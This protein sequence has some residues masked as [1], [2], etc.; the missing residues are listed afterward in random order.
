MRKFFFSSLCL[1]LLPLVVAAQQPLPNQSQ[2]QQ[3]AQPQLPAASSAVATRKP[4]VLATMLEAITLCNEGAQDPKLELLVHALEFC[5]VHGLDGA[6]TVANLLDQLEPGGPKGD[7]QVGYTATLQL[8][9]L[10]KPTSDGRG[11]KIDE[12]AVDEV[13]R[14]I[15]KV[16]RPVV[17]Y[18]MGG[19]FDSTGPITGE[20]AK[21]ESNF[22]HF[23][24]GS[25]PDLGYF[26]Y[27]IAPYTLLSDPEIPVNRLRFD[28]L[29]YFA[30]RIAAL[31]ETARNRIIA[32]T[33]MGEVHQLFPDFE[34][35]VG[36][37]E[38][39][40]VTDYSAPSI[41]QFRDWLKSEYHSIA[42]F[43]EKTGFSYASF[44]EVPA[45]SKDIRR[46]RLESFAEHY[47]AFADGTL[48]FS[49]WLWDPK[50]Q[51]A[52][53]ELYIDA[54]RI[55]EVPRGQ[56]RLDVYRALEEVDD[57]NIGFRIDYD[58]S[59]LAPGR[60]VA[61][62]VAESVDGKRHPLA[63]SEFT[64][65]A[66]DQAAPPPGALRELASKADGAIGGVRSLL[67]RVRRRG[68]DLLDGELTGVRS[69]LD[70]PK[71]QQDIYFNPLARDWNA[72]RA[73][74]VER[75]LATVYQVALDAGLPADKLYSHQIVPDVNSTWNPQL[76]AVGKTIGRTLPWK[77]G[78]NMYGGATDSN[79]MRS[80]MKER[81]I[82][83][84][85]VPEFNPQQWKRDGVAL[86]ALKS[87]YDAGARFVS[88]YY[89]SLVPDRFKTKTIANGLNN[90]EL[91]PTNTRD[92]SNRFYD[93]IVEFA[94]R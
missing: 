25:V 4:L 20:L 60:H 23:A 11:W 54:Q 12:V 66:R 70:L 3:L 39:I 45:P 72:F 30:K 83:D 27:R 55:G 81:G 35:G 7:V 75:F 61:Q 62:I 40:R 14:V 82:T 93:A 65:V 33:L 64:L 41:A 91:G 57:P 86:Q 9:G 76:F 69:W 73:W 74:Q 68:S 89:F 22:M 26:G 63:R 8:L 31:P 38:D 67:E 16:D 36:R 24:D 13:L 53:L 46:E 10:Y 79:W 34:N 21:D 17:V 85:G 6:T 52:R 28:A 37:Y 48:P 77:T 19:H 94:K 80:Y 44:A 92:G 18:F 90:M 29:R 78:L 50:K 58:F 42:A 2:Q 51:V 32:F 5:R 88:P 59:K 47:D 1:S 15:E 43:N 56:N 84:Y 87:H 71:A 49:G